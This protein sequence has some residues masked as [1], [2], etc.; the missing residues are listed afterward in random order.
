MNKEKEDRGK[1]GEKRGE[2][3]KNKKRTD[4]RS[5]QILCFKRK[6]VEN[7]SFAIRRSPHRDNQTPSH[8]RPA[9]SRRTFFG[10]STHFFPCSFWIFFSPLGL[11]SLFSLFLSCF[12]LFPE[13]IELRHNTQ[14]R[15]ER[16]IPAIARSFF[17]VF[18]GGSVFCPSLPQKS[19]RQETKKK[20][21][22]SF[23]TFWQGMVDL[24]SKL[25]RLSP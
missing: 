6:I 16:S 19:H 20:T 5:N 18:F 23:L 25:S 1:K 17:V 2:K 14:K 7:C 8:R 9:P 4:K 15:L 12:R 13:Y 11:P 21:I 3:T 10:F 24:S 22:Y